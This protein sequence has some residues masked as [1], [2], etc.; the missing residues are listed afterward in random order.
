MPMLLGGGSSQEQPRPVSPPAGLGPIL[1]VRSSVAAW[2]A[3]AYV[4]SLEHGCDQ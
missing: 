2:F 4:Q 1:Q 3:Y